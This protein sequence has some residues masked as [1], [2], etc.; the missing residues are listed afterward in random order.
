MLCLKVPKSEGEK[1]RNKLLERDMLNKN[2]KIISN[3]NYLFIPIKDRPDDLDYEVVKKDIEY[4]EIKSRDYREFID[5]PEE[6]K[7][8]LPTSFDIIGDIA[9]IKI[10]EGLEEYKSKIGEAI[11]EVHKNVRTVMQDHGVVGEF[12]VREVENI[13]GEDRKTTIHREYGAEFEVDVSD[14]YFSPRLATERW[15][16]VKQ[17]LPDEKVLD[18]F[19]GVGPYSILI[20][21]NVDVEKIFS[22]DI[23]PDAISLL[24]RNIKRNNVEDVVEVYQGDAKE[25]APQFSVDRIIMNLPHSS[26]EFLESALKATEKKCILHYYEM[27][28]EVEE[29]RWLKKVKDKISD[30]GYV[31]EIR[32]VRDVK[33]YS[34]YMKHKALDI[35]LKR[36]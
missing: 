20:A 33:S 16:V 35:E 5:M 1:V 26:F 19:T 31:P 4:R 8:T 21:N 12:R 15:R 2:G 23:N 34:A 3:E 25:L 36:S 22:I 17:A 28:E 29:K 10:P 14:A 24:K 18:M 30:C 27:V 7:D 6:V 9:I 11:L 13:A 32:N